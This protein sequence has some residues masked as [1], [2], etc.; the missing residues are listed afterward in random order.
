MTK[1]VYHIM[2]SLVLLLFFILTLSTS[3]Y[4]SSFHGTGKLKELNPVDGRDKDRGHCLFFTG[5]HGD[6]LEEG[7]FLLF[8]IDDEHEDGLELEL[9][10]TFE[11]ESDKRFKLFPD[12]EFAE[13]FLE[14]VLSDQLG[15]GN[16]DL[17]LSK[18]R[19]SVVFPRSIG[20]DELINCRIRLK[21]NLMDGD[22]AIDRFKLSYNGVGL[23]LADFHGEFQEDDASSEVVSSSILEQ[24]QGSCPFPN[25]TPDG[26]KFCEP[27]TCLLNFGD[28][29]WWTL[30]HYD[31]ANGFYYNGG[32]Q[33]IFSPRNAFVDS[34]GLH[35]TVKMDNLGGGDQW[36]GS[37]VVAVRNSDG[38]QA[39]LG[40]GTYLVSMKV[41]TA[42][43]W[44]ELDRNVALGL[45][46]YQKDKSGDENNP[47]RELDL[48]EISRWGNPPGTS[49]D[50]CK[51]TPKLLCDGNAQ[52]ALQLWNIDA[53]KNVHRY[54][55]ADGADEITLVMEWNAANQPV[56]FRQY[57]G[58][59]TLANLPANPD[60]EFTTPADRN[61]FIPNNDCQRFHIN[62]W[63]G[64]FGEAVKGLNPGPS[65]GQNQEVVITNFQYQPLN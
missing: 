34:E 26:G 35:L 37:E 17:D 46:T 60:N 32:L 57:N 49:R 42:S 64:N 43:S 14:G 21:G 19:A 30:Y 15:D 65:S 53:T 1:R 39:S 31:P 3:V 41:K 51:L 27:N 55:I 12:E 22:E 23:H 2:G 40:F 13:G 50:N 33:T 20:A 52:F 4:G 63:M 28:F 48:A 47:Y 54:T 25:L 24:Q 62:F 61:P 5:P 9:F 18:L 36:A 56:A 10:G 11:M 44:S 6:F 16:V 38:T 29:Q 45:F 8:L 7:Q 59:F 58:R